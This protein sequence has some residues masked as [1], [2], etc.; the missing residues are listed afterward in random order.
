MKNGDLILTIDGEP[1]QP[2]S[3]SDAV[4]RI[5]GEADTVVVLGVRRKEQDLELRIT[6]G[7]VV[8][9]SVETKALEGAIGYARVD[10]VSRATGSEFQ[11]KVGGLGRVAR[12]GARP[13]RQ[14]GRRHVGRAAARRLLSR[15]SS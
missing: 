9:P 1:T 13:A 15:P 10:Q 2:L 7:D 6:R 3:V 4:D 11:S 8:V 12:P 14:L 5:R